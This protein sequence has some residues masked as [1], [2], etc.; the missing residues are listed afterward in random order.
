MNGEVPAFSYFYG[1]EVPIVSYM[2]RNMN[3]C[4]GTVCV[5]ITY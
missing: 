5:L 2:T 4:F 3:L 1:N